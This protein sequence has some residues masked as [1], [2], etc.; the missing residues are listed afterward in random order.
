MHRKLA[1][2]AGSSGKLKRWVANWKDNDTVLIVK[3]DVKIKVVGA[4]AY[5]ISWNPIFRYE[6]A[7]I[8]SFPLDDGP[9]IVPDILFLQTLLLKPK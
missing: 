7:I 8:N 6:K 9:K 3:R 5:T 2:Y 1:V 4:I